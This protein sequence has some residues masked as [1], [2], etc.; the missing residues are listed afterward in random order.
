MKRAALITLVVVA[1]VLLALV[2]AWLLL[3]GKVWTFTFTQPQIE[4]AL[5]KRF[6]MRKRHLLVLEMIYEHPRVALTE[7]SDVI[8]VG[9]DARLDGTVNGRELKGSADLTTRVAYDAPTGAFVLHDAHLE[10][11]AIDGVKDEHMRIAK[12]LTNGWAAEK[13]SGIPVYTLRPT[14]VKAAIARLVLR[15][16]AVR[17]DALVVEVGL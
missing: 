12:E 6:P 4:Q 11:I 5:G 3:R 2:A 14:E 7:G 8:G 17:D 13:V 9:I 15:S 10:R 1:V 16:A